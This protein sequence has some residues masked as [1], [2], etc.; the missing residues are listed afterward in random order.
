MPDTNNRRPK[1]D[2]SAPHPRSLARP[3]QTHEGE[4]NGSSPASA[5]T[6]GASSPLDNLFDGPAPEEITPGTH[7]NPLAAI[8]DSPA[9]LSASTEAGSLAGS[10]TASGQP[11]GP[12]EAPQI[13]K[14]QGLALDDLFTPGPEPEAPQERAGDL[15]AALGWADGLEGDALPTADGPAPGPSHEIG[16]TGDDGHRSGLAGHEDRR[17]AQDSSSAPARSA[18]TG[19]LAGAPKAPLKLGGWRKGPGAGKEG[20][21]PTANIASS[22]AAATGELRPQSSG[23]LGRQQTAG[24]TDQRHDLGRD[25]T[26]AVS[27]WHTPGDSAQVR[28]LVDDGGP[29]QAQGPGGETAQGE[30]AQGE[31]AQQVPPEAGPVDEDAGDFVAQ[32]DRGS[33]EV[34]LTGA[35]SDRKPRRTEPLPVDLPPD[36]KAVRGDDGDCA[37]DVVATATGPAAGEDEPGGDGDGQAGPSRD[38]RAPSRGCVLL[39][40][41]EATHHRGPAEADGSQAAPADSSSLPFELQSGGLGTALVGSGSADA[42]ERPIDA[43]IDGA[44][45]AGGTDPAAGL[46]GPAEPSQHQ[47]PSEPHALSSMFEY[48]PAAGAQVPGALTDGGT[49][50]D[51]LGSTGQVEPAPGPAGHGGLGI[52]SRVEQLLASR[53]TTDDSSVVRARYDIEAQRQRYIALDRYYVVV[54][55]ILGLVSQL[56]ELHHLNRLELTRDSQLDARQRRQFQDAISRAMP[57]NNIAIAAADIEIVFDLAYDELIGLG[58]LGELWRDPEVTDIL[59]DSWDRVVVERNGVLQETPVRFRNHDHARDLARHLAGK[60]S[61]RTLSDQH[62]LVTAELPGARANLVLGPVVKRGVAISLRKSQNLL[63]IEALLQRGSIS[64]A[65]RDFLAACVLSRATIVVSGGTGSGKTTMVN[66]LSQ[67]IPATERV[68]TI[69]DSYELMLSARHVVSLQTKERASAD[70]EIHITQEMLL[71]NSL[72]MRPDRIVV[73]E[74]REGEGARVMLQAANTGHDGTMTTIHANDPDGA[75]DRLAD[76]LRSAK[77]VP[78]DVAKR[79]VAQAIDLVVQVTRRRGLRYVSAISAVDRSC[80]R[81]GP[82]SASIAATT[83]FEGTLVDGPDG[84]PVPRFRQVG[85]VGPDTDLG[86]KLSDAGFADLTEAPDSPIDD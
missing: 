78:D 10:E 76:L 54:N 57:N 39:P 6:T 52:A 38:S 71:V 34:S 50:S 69:E 24:G 75:L 53:M 15:G 18:P 82:T 26:S 17:S 67:F 86:T 77:A 73:G 31:T 60:M 55:Q 56:P 44:L 64:T 37:T 81:Q 58:P 63:G 79:E 14:A 7:G 29:W 11:S 23:S 74:I 70:D 20:V 48:D 28:A 66:A 84:Q 72:R 43:G 65:I 68:I 59:V 8:W 2:W 27:G 62:P 13:S 42:A 19:W 4:G 21:R 33:D 46:T 85:S 36:D 5:G 45:D 25:E 51:A 80:V 49:E 35:D 30:T 12:S 22:D 32:C 9:G 40:S 3:P 41:D 1:T 16:R 61:D 83:I 47:D